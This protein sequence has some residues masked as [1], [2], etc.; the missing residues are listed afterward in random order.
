MQRFFRLTTFLF[1]QNLAL[2][3]QIVRERIEAIKN[4][5][6]KNVAKFQL[7]TACRLSEAVGKYAVHSTDLTQTNYKGNNLALW[8]LKTAKREGILRIIA[9]PCNQQWVQ[10]M[11]DLFQSR[12]KQVFDYGPSSV[13]HLLADELGNLEYFIEKYHIYEKNHLPGEKGIVIRGH[14]RNI[15]THALRHL[16]LSEL[17]NFYGFD[18][19]DLAIFAGWKFKGMTGRY[20]TG[21]WGRY[22]DKLIV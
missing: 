13:A 1:E 14:Q 22:I 3:I 16:R 18:D 6:L 15:C 19:I 12:Q 11:I 20:A 10:E 17:V 2:S 8:T 9:L 21:A 4:E 7:L 5:K